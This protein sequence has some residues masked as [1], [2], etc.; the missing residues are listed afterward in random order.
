MDMFLQGLAFAAVFA[1][2]YIVG[3]GHRATRRRR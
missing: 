3:S 2:G 1:I